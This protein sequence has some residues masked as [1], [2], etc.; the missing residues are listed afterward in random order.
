MK[1]WQHKI[2][3]TYETEPQKNKLPL[4]V[5]YVLRIIVLGLNIAAIYIF[6]KRN[7]TF[8]AIIGILFLIYHIATLFFGTEIKNYILMNYSKYL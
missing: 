2:L 4:W 3:D 8:M 7:S 6:Y 1:N 5:H